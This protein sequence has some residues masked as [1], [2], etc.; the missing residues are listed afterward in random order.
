MSEVP[1]RRSV[2]YIVVLDEDLNRFD[3]IPKIGS[4]PR[5]VEAQSTA[6][7]PLALYKTYK[8]PSARCRKLVN[9]GGFGC[10]RRYEGNKDVCLDPAVVPPRTRCLVYSFG[11]A[12]DV[13][14]E[15]SLMSLLDCEVHLY[16]P[17]I[18]LI[19]WNLEKPRAKQIFHSEAL[20]HR[21]TVGFV[22]GQRAVMKT[23]DTLL[24][25]NRH[26]E[27]TIHYLKID[28]E[29]DEWQVLQHMI[30][31]NLL[32]NV[33]QLSMEIHSLDLKNMPKSSWMTTLKERFRILNTLEEIG[34]RR[35]SVHDNEHYLCRVD[36]TG[37]DDNTAMPTITS[38]SSAVTKSPLQ[39][40]DHLRSIVES[41]RRNMDGIAN[42]GDHSHKDKA[43]IKPGSVS[44][45]KIFFSDE[46]KM[47]M[48]SGTGVRNKRTMGES[49][50]DGFL[51]SQ[52]RSTEN[53]PFAFITGND[54]NE[55][56]L[57]VCQEVLYVRVASRS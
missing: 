43:V 16:D 38:S 49:S 30:A 51:K 55:N 27:D 28:I 31:Y 26:T 44:N 19:G 54:N 6:H 45:K 52:N 21:P 32:D 4:Q 2:E 25:L 39:T 40:L 8:K 37:V 57:H 3:D 56:L 7:S 1:Y 29:G 42:V 11:V 48:S 18:N 36:F 34:F 50:F 15:D 12:N 22:L 35:V 53:I 20:Y 33:I 10:T 13:T 17:T 14:F 9:M 23:F 5:D 47:N 41:T 24:A 46:D